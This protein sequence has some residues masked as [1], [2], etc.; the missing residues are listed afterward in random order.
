MPKSKVTI[1]TPMG[2]TMQTVTI[3]C[4]D[5][6]IEQGPDGLKILI[7]AG[8]GKVVYSTIRSIQVRDDIQ[9]IQFN[10]DTMILL[11]KAV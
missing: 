1:L 5:P 3:T 4:T 7:A 6:S 10:G 9:S 8:D 2:G 11:Q